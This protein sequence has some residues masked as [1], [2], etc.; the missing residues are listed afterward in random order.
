M[1]APV[2]WGAEVFAGFAGS[3]GGESAGDGAGVC[4]DLGEGIVIMLCGVVIVVMKV[5]K[6]GFFVR[7]W[8]VWWMICLESPWPHVWMVFFI[9]YDC[10]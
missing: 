5:A 9:H 8:T 4:G 6:G 1:E 2:G 7:G 10:V 3:Y